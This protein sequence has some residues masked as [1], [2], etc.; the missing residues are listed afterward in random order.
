M[1]IELHQV[2]EERTFGPE[3]QIPGEPDAE[4]GFDGEHRNEGENDGVNE[5]P[6]T[7]VAWGL[8]SGGVVH[9][10]SGHGDEQSAGYEDGGWIGHI[11]K[12]RQSGVVYRR[13]RGDSPQKRPV[14]V[15][16][17]LYWLE[18]PSGL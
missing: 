11:G 5:Q 7:R 13:R 14:A 2:C 18:D 3:V 4:G 9:S 12:V 15:P 1:M 16:A 17:I 8:D 10:V 6:Q